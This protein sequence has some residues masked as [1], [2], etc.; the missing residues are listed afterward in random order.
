MF[1]SISDV[2]PGAAVAR[3]T[4]LTGVASGTSGILFPW[5]TGAIVDRMSYGPV[6][7]MAALMPMLG[8]LILFVAL[9]RYQPVN[10]DDASR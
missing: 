8:V 7:L 3:V 1:A 10:L 2:F 4:G 6:F 5:L 9:G